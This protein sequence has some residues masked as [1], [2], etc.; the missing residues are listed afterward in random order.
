MVCRAREDIGVYSSGKAG[1]CSSSVAEAG[2]NHSI[3]AGGTVLGGIGS[4]S[5][6]EKLGGCVEG[7]N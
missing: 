1:D 5:G 7:E 3:V 2:G 4:G 6:T